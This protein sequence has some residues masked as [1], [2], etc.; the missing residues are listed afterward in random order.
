MAQ[1]DHDVTVD[2][3]ASDDRTGSDA[4]T[5]TPRRADPAGAVMQLLA[6]GVPLTLLAD[7]A[8]P[9]GPASQVILETEGLPDD[10]WWET[11]SDVEAASDEASDELPVDPEAAHE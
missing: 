9:D 3:D 6:E 7:L 1:N 4:S 5:P 11:D 2:V 10:A 8:A